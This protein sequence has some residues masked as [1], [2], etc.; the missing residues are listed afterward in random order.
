MSILIKQTNIRMK[1][2][3]C[4]F[5]GLPNRGAL[6]TQMN[7]ECIVSLWCYSFNDVYYSLKL[8]T[9]CVQKKYELQSTH[10]FKNIGVTEIQESEQDVFMEGTPGIKNNNL[11]LPNAT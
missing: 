7:S 9:L 5:I 2:I 1:S 8:I 11:I 4:F 3:V 6:I 10:T